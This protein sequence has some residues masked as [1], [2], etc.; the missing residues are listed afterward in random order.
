MGM[1]QAIEILLEVIDHDDD[2]DNDGDGDDDD[3]DVQV[4]IYSPYV[5]TYFF[6]NT[7]DQNHSRK[8]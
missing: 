1:K 2:D 4:V 6:G 7:S 3:D 8:E 5:L